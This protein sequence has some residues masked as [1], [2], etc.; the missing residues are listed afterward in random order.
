V[1]RVCNGCPKGVQ[2]AVKNFSR[3]PTVFHRGGPSLLDSIR[4]SAEKPCPSRAIRVCMLLVLLADRSTEWTFGPRSSIERH[5][6]LPFLRLSGQKQTINSI[7]IVLLEASLQAT[8]YMCTWLS[9]GN[10]G[11]RWAGSGIWSNGHLLLMQ[12]FSQGS[13]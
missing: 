1:Q 6:I 9:P 7:S 8:P 13:T 4:L 12:A 5:L 11:S 2:R 10:D 3:A